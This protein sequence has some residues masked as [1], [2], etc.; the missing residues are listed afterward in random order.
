MKELLSGNQAIARGAYEAGC[1]FAAAYPGTP[2]TEILETISGYP[3][4]FAEWAPNEKVALEAATGASFCGARSIVAMKHVGLNVAADPLFT[5]SYTGTRGGIVIV[6]ADDPGMHSSQNE[7]D[8]RYYAIAAKVPM[9]EPSDSQEARDFTIRAFELSEKFDTPVLLRITTRIAHSECLVEAGARIAL[10]RKYTFE[11]EPEK[12]VMVPAF[13]RLRHVIVEKRLK[14]LLEYSENCPENVIEKRGADAGV[15]TGG[16]SYQY[17]RDV[18]PE[19][20]VL[21]LGFTHPLPEALIR[22]FAATVKTLWVVEELEPIIENHV[23]ALGIRAAA[24]PEEFRCGELTPAIVRSFILGTQAPKET[25]NAKSRPPIL[26]AGCPHRGVFYTLNRLKITTMGDIGCYALGVAP[27][28]NSLDTCVDMGASICH[29]A[30][31][32]HVVSPEEQ[33]RIVSVIGDS[34]FIHS[35]IT[36]LIDAVYNKANMT[37]LLLD[38]RTTAMT[39]GQHHPGTGKT[40]KD[41]DTFQLD[42][43]RMVKACGVESVRVIDPY[44]LTETREAIEAA[45]A[46]PGVSVVMTQQPCR[47]IDRG[48]WKEPYA[49]DEEKCKVCGACLNLGCPAIINRSTA[50]KKS[51]P[52]INAL[53]CVGCGL[54][55]QVCKVEA[56]AVPAAAAK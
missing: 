11:R 28:L 16:I 9:L 36:S 3:E 38:N 20:S 56:I 43:M 54:C 55:A 39:G 53:L 4:V 42:L 31:A 18:L 45:V 32:S 40:I 24:K 25:T 44:D 22:K 8:N 23:K 2:S 10:N 5:L 37:L 47:L 27:P 21:K 14:A 29:A 19:A 46:E 51:A 13:A 49:I 15:I 50:E 1:A 33:K 35:G 48:T 34:T 6:T 7:Q 41:E 17:V 30:G 12:F 52:E 26:C